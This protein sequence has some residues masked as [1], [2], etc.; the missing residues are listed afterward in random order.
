M[1]YNMAMLS[2]WETGGKA[3]NWLWTVSLW[4]PYIHFGYSQL[5]TIQEKAQSN[6]LKMRILLDE[7][8]EVWRYY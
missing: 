5:A 6:H 2:F 3:K 1:A 7:H 4:K 8:S